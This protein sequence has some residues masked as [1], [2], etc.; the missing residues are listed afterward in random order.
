LARDG[1]D[2]HVDL[3]GSEHAPPHLPYPFTHHGVLSAARLG[4]MYR[5]ASIG[6]VF[7]ATNYSI[8][9]R[10]MMACGLPVVEL[11][12]DS[13][14]LSF[15]NGIAELSDPTPESVAAHLKTLLLD[16][17]RREQLTRQALDFLAGFSWEQSA[18]DIE[19]ALLSRLGRAPEPAYECETT[20]RMERQ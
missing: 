15:P 11:N 13:S 9:P 7:S 17:R 19:A 2:F 18:R 1:F 4:A 10:E 20:N 6:M 12:S 14:R 5:R 3:F 16:R 8:I